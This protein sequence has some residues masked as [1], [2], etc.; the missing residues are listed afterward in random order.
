MAWRKLMNAL[1]A[2]VPLRSHFFR[3]KTPH[4]SGV[5]LC[6]KTGLF[7][8]FWPFLRSSKFCWDGVKLPVA[9]CG[10]TGLFCD[11]GRC[12]KAGA[13]TRHCHF[14]EKKCRTGPAFMLQNGPFSPKI[15]RLPFFK[16]IRAFHSRHPDIA[17]PLRRHGTSQKRRFG[18]WRRLMR[19]QEKR[20]IRC[21][22]QLET[23]M[24]HLETAVWFLIK[25]ILQTGSAG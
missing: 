6:Y 24:T 10:V 21:M 22:T 1:P 8:I 20:T 16:L 23:V 14:F 18:G 7:K 19:R 11:V 25:K 5:Y 4:W 3:N 17:A 12:T 2:D 15:A 9:R 13:R